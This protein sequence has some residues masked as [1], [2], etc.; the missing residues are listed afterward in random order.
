MDTE[1]TRDEL[2]QKLNHP[3]KCRPDQPECLLINDAA[4]Q[5]QCGTF[6]ERE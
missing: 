2:K 5:G 6:L 4:Q 1:I 3:K